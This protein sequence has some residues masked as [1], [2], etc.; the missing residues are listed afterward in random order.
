[1][2]L[3]LTL[4]KLNMMKL[5]RKM[6]RGALAALALTLSGTAPAL[7][8]AYTLVAWSD[9]GLHEFDATDAS[10]YALALPGNTIRAQLISSGR[11]VT[12]TTGIVV[13]Y[14]A[15]ADASGSI[16]T[17]SS[18]KVNF[19]QYAAS[20]VGKPLKADQ[21]A[22]GFNM[23]G[24]GNTPQAMVFDPASSV[25]SA[26]GIPITPYDD[27]G[28]RNPLPMM[29]VTASTP[30]GA[31]LATTTIPLPV[32][33][34]MDCRA[35][36]A[37]GSPDVARPAGGWAWDCDPV[38]DYKLNILRYHD[39][40]KANWNVYTN[41]LLAAGYNPEG[42]EATVV[43][44]GRSVSC[45]ACHTSNANPGGGVAGMRPLTQLIH[46]KH[47][48]VSDP[49]SGAPITTMTNSASCYLCHAGGDGLYERGL[50]RA[51]VRA[52]GALT[53]QCQSCHGAVADVGNPARKGWVDL[54]NCQA[55][56]T[57]TATAN[58]GL[59]QTNALTAPN[60]YRQA[61]NLTFGTGG[62]IPAAG[63]N[64]AS[65]P[66]FHKSAGHGG[67]QC[68]ACHGPA[69]AELSSNRDNDNAQSIALQGHGGTLT[70]C[71]AC[72]T[73]RPSTS[74]GGPHGL[75]PVDSSWASNH[76]GGGGSS[77]AACHGS[78]FTGTPLAGAA[79]ARA[80][81]TRSFWAGFQ[82]GCYSC[83]NGP[84]GGDG[85]TSHPGLTTANASIVSVAGAPGSVT[86][87]IAGAGAGA[88]RIVTPPAHGTAT[89]NGSVASYFPAPGYAGQ[90]SFTVAAWNGWNDSSLATVTASV[91]AAPGTWSVNPVAP[92]AILPGRSTPFHAQPS[93]TGTPTALTFD[94]DF[95][96]GSPHGT[97][98]AICHNYAAEGTY[99]WTL[100]VH[101]GG[102]PQTFTGAVVVSATLGT[103][104][105]L[106]IT[107]LGWA[108]NLEWNAD[109]IPTSVET[110]LDLNDP[111]SWTPLPDPPTLNGSVYDLQEYLLPGSQFFRL[112]RVP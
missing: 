39:G 5:G 38:R 31:V 42:L 44:D 105:D 8:A 40:S 67:L 53:M 108:V 19:F 86:V 26:T 90:D 34:G 79:G 23:P 71:T 55:C 2:R 18:G 80:F 56:H 16:N 30:Q 10:V 22:S 45:L 83:H 1:L 103:P 50:H 74:T 60:V 85:G 87:P 75:H 9:A 96:D 94:W 59:Y 35:C 52:D 61:V 102:Q 47:A 69:H 28:R 107:S 43:K 89:V 25:F 46:T 29:R 49:V 3:Q 32:S 21:G 37:S 27:L 81:R 88:L 6:V 98:A 14:Q 92:A 78:K 12:S 51:S 95:G 64:Y 76:E 70:D 36:H 100:T 62:T 91:T 65:A 4:G 54:P 112:R 109:N 48:F 63:T 99:N 111:H 17:T 33:D 11:L 66:L 73:T 15:V 82:I 104:L 72:H 58:G 77:C 24:P 93:F 84:N 41:S 110:S 20:L 13:T 57:G 101:G 97:N 68:A 7:G 106:A